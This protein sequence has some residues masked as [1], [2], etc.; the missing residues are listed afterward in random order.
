MNVKDISIYFF[1]KTNQRATPA[2]FKKTGSQIKNLIESGYKEEEIIK[3][4]DYLVENPPP[5]GFYSIGYLSYTINDVLQKI[6]LKE[7]RE[8][9]ELAIQ[10]SL[11]SVENSKSN[12]EKFLNK[13]KN[14]FKGTLKIN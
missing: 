13:K 14:R 2:M 8:K 3:C 10:D 5:K 12:S 4:I 11:C 9:S 1:E 6:K 7:L